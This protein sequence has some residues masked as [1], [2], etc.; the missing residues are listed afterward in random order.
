MREH[1]VGACLDEK[2]VQRQNR[3]VP[4]VRER[5]RGCGG[6]GLGEQDAGGGLQADDGGPLIVKEKVSVS[7]GQ[8]V[9]GMW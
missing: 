3:V 1:H 8:S 6:E 2:N 9:F 7:Y 4:C 5:R